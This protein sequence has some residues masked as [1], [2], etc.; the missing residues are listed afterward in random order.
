MSPTSKACSSEGVDVGE[1]VIVDEARVGGRFRVAGDRFC[2]CFCCCILLILE[3]L[4]LSISLCRNLG[5]HDFSCDVTIWSNHSHKLSGNRR[6]QQL[7]RATLDQ[8]IVREGER[9]RA[10]S[11]KCSGVIGGG[12]IWS[13][14]TDLIGAVTLLDTGDD[15]G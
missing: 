7:H 10:H 11:N 4:Y 8:S 2:C 3:F 1:R 14:A 6:E 9:R 5:S 12:R 13:R 15:V